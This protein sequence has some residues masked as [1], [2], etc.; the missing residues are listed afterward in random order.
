MDKV[1]G[2]KLYKLLDNKKLP[3]TDI[4]RVQKAIERYE[5]W[6]RDLNTAEYSD[7]D[8]AVE[9]MVSLLNDYKLYVDVDLI[10]DS[11]NDF[12]YRQK[13][14]LKLDNTVMEE[15]LPHLVRKCIAY[16][17]VGVELE[18]DSQA[19]VF[20]SIHFESSITSPAQ[21]GGMQI[22][23][24]DQDFSIYRPLYIQASHNEDMSQAVE[25]STCLGYVC[26]ELKTNLDKTMFQEASATAHDVRVAVTGAKYY[27]LADYLDMSPISTS[28][29]DI[30]EIMVLR[31]AKR[32]G[33]GI[34]SN[35]STFAGRQAGRNEY[36]SYLKEHPYSAEVFKRFISKLLEQI[37]SENL[38][39]EEVLSEGWF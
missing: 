3:S 12:L 26:A 25:L 19:K 17:N 13:G 6:V 14:Q 5:R 32:L 22:K 24:K 27:L 9:G 38:S 15:F 34:R 39:E 20:S 11:E 31:K 1:H 23:S 4:P 16:A 7:I 2:E 35:Y 30:E 33:S 29:T 21:G 18:I 28:T 8:S 36:V 37:S 10:F